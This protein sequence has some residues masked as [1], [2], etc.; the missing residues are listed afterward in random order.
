MFETP[1]HYKRCSLLLLNTDTRRE[2]RCVP[3]HPAGSCGHCIGPVVINT[4]DVELKR[5]CSVGPLDA[6]GSAV[7]GAVKGR[8]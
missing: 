6:R 7:V 5:A 8:L 4:G 3:F 2:A 1:T